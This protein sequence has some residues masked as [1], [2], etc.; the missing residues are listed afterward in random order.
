MK[1]KDIKLFLNEHRHYF[2]DENCCNID[3][4]KTGKKYVFTCEKGHKFEALVTNVVKKDGFHCSVCSGRSVQIGVNDIATTHPYCIEYL[5][6]KS[7]AY[8]YSFGSNVKIEWKCPTCKNVV[9]K[10]P[11]KFLQLKNFCQICS[12]H[13]SYPEKYIREFLIQL[14]IDF[15]HGVKFSWSNKIYDFYIKQYNCIIEVNGMQHYKENCFD[16][17]GGRTYRQ[18]CDN[19]LNKYENA[20]K[21]GIDNYI[22]IDARKSDPTWM[23]N[24]IINSDIKKWKDI[25]FDKIDWNLCHYNSL[26]SIVENV[27]NDYKNGEHNLHILSKRYNKSYNTIKSYLKQAA[28]SGLCDYSVEKS[29]KEAYT[30]NAKRVVLTQSKPVIQLSINEDYIAEYKSIQEAQR[31]LKISHIWDC[32]KGIRNTAGGFKWRYKNEEV[33]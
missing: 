20:I 6:D 18:E 16:A 25:S 14:G 28:I 13:I 30:N 3:S 5:V 31:T 8:K 11:N 4:I 23:K 33:V 12:D 17:Y 22:T 24:S 21:N 27:A 1:I 10:S 9:S 26:K 32:I 2:S 15:K 7:N 29:L 19:D